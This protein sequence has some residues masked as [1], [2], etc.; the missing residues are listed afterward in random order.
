MITQSQQQA[1][2]QCIL[3]RRIFW[4]ANQ[5]AQAHPRMGEAGLTTAYQFIASILEEAGGKQIEIGNFPY[6]PEHRYWGWSTERKPFSELAE[7]YLILPDGREIRLCSTLEDPTCSMGAFR[8]TLPDGEI[9]EVMEVG[10]GAHP[11]DYRNQPLPGKLILASGELFSAVMVEALIHRHAEGLLCGPGHSPVHQDLVIGRQL[12]EP[13]LFSDRRPFGFNL[14]ARQYRQL[15]QQLAATGTLRVK[16]KIKVTLDNGQ[17]PVVSA[18]L[19]GSDFAEEHVVLL[20]NWGGTKASGIGSSLAMASLE[21]ILRCLATTIVQGKLTPL[22]RSLQLLI[23]PGMESLVAWINARQACLPQI[24]AVIH[25]TTLAAHPTTERI[26]IH[27]TPPAQPS[28]IPD[29]LCASFQRMAAL[30]TRE[31]IPVEPS[32]E[33]D[34]PPYWPGLPVLPWIDNQQNIPAIGVDFCLHH[35]SSPELDS[36]RLHGQWH[37]SLAALTSG[38]GDLCSLQEEDLPRQLLSSQLAGINRLTRY[39]DS[40]HL[41]AQHELEKEERSSTTVRHYLWLAETNMKDLLAREQQRL[42]SC[43]R[44]LKGPG[45]QALRLAETQS[46]LEQTTEALLRSLHAEM[47]IWLGPRARLAL[48]RRPY[49][50]LERR[51]Q[52]VRVHRHFSGPF[53]LPQ[54]LREATP[55]DRDW[56]VHHEMALATQPVGEIAIPYIDSRRNLLEIYERLNA[57]Y[58]HTDLRLLWRYFEVL[59]NIGLIQ[60]EEIPQ[61]SLPNQA[62]E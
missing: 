38:V 14:S 21:E 17:W 25:L 22:R 9:F 11:A 44:Y 39:T 41:Q 26:V 62:G 30:T 1:I 45:A 33:L 24:K 4:R 18:F 6:G 19:P 12:G 48:R 10:A 50:A 57:I 23:T 5:L 47:A 59:Q 60:F 53:P 49:S 40:L 37:Q 52:M 54:L 32:L 34:C 43:G 16:A 7:L 15:Q 8:S 56:L 13:S 35:L 46:D 61:A 31:S 29:L 3:P 28:F 55:A 36:F 20:A 27:D 51:A 42:K 58:P 2:Y